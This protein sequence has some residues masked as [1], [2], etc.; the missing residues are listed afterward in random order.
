MD[1]SKVLNNLKLD[2]WYRA[3]FYVGTLCLIASLFF[4]VKGVTNAQL[5]LLSL[6]AICLGLGEWKNHKVLSWIK[7]ANAYTGGPAL[8][9]APVR[10]PDVVGK[11]L[12]VLGIVLLCI[13]TCAIL[14]SSL[15]TPPS[16]P[17]PNTLTRNQVPESK[18]ATTDNQIDQLVY[19]LY[20]LPPEEIKIV[21]DATK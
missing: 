18:T 8:M 21:E 13:G 11:I 5:Q 12:D 19:E 20:N 10:S 6:G 4:E 17:D 15:L 7:P 1:V 14:R 16:P 3:V 2:V 9:T